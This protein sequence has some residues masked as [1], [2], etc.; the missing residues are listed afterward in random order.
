M[1]FAEINKPDGGYG[2][3]PIAIGTEDELLENGLTVREFKSLMG[4]D[5]LVTGPDGRRT[6]RT[7]IAYDPEDL[8]DFR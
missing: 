2:K 3:P 5:S 4:E 8:G 1:S 6:P 7:D